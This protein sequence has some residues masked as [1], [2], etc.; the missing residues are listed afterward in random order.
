M[1]PGTTLTRADEGKPVVDPR[2]TV[3]GRVV[4]VEQG[5]AYVELEPPAPATLA[6]KLGRVIGD[7]DTFPLRHR[8]IE[9]VDR[10]A[11]RVDPER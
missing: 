1:R 2:D 8:A 5:I 11:V 7:A 3:V 9:T 10:E 6:S 4:E